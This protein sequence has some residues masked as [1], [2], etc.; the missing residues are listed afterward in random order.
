MPLRMAF[1]GTGYISRIHAKAARQLDNVELVAVVNHRTES[2]VA[3]GDTFGITRRYIDINDL[4]HDGDVDAVI[5]STPNY[6]HAPQTIAALNAGIHVM[7]EK[8]MAMNASEA[9]AMQ[10]ASI[11]SGALLMVAHCWRF[12]EEVLWLKN[13]IDS[14]ELGRPVRTKGYGVHSNWGPTGWFVER[15]FAG[16]GALADMG[17]HSIDTTRFLLGDPKPLSV[18]ARIGTHYGEYNVDDTGIMIIQWENGVTSY[19]ESGWWQPHMD[20]PEACTQVYGTDGFGQVFPTLIKTFDCETGTVNIEQSGFPET[21]DPHCPQAMYDAQMRYF[22]ECVRD[23]PPPN[24]GATEGLINM[25][26]VDAA[27]ESNR[28][29]KVINLGAPQTGDITWR[30]GAGT[31]I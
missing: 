13:R 28:N 21:R 7:V 1:V 14:G 17:I 22:C 4:I 2:M 9:L 29:S 31:G 18:Y 8:P 25:R 20:G 11:K 19:I 3:F 16:G 12:D 6:L 24:P 5:I 23:G 26:I 15:Q 10:D 30:T 27:Y